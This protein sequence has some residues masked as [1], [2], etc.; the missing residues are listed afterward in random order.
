MMLVL[1]CSITAWS[2]LR[3]A[4]PTGSLA[5]D[6]LCVAVLLLALWAMGS[7][8]HKS[9]SDEPKKRLSIGL[10]LLLVA[11]TISIATEPVLPLPEPGMVGASPHHALLVAAGSILAGAAAFSI[12]MIASA[13]R[14]AFDR[15]RYYR[16]NAR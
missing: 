10:A 15:W 13:C 2:F 12:V 16:R 6:V 11:A 3:K 8:Y 14:Q 5:W 7:V 4:Y 1:A 9:W